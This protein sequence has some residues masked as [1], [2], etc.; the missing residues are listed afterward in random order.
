MLRLTAKMPRE[1]GTMMNIIRAS[2]L[3]LLLH[4]HH[5]TDSFGL[6]MALFE[7]LQ[8]VLIITDVM[9]DQTSSKAIF[10]KCF[11]DIFFAR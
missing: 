6:D 9:P 7:M 3:Q 1:G 4:Q 5:A 11:Q 10:S 8:N 2:L